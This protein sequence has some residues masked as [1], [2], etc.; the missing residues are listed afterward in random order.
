MQHFAVCTYLLHDSYKVVNNQDTI[1]H[2]A[3]LVVHRVGISIDSI[4]YVRSIY[5][6][7]YFLTASLK[8]LDYNNYNIDTTNDI[9]ACD[10]HVT[11]TYMCIIYNTVTVYSKYSY[12]DTTMQLILNILQGRAENLFAP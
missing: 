11:I 9:I 3:I 4:Y 6:L 10:P 7:W 1:S 5:Y 8:M 2:K 12:P